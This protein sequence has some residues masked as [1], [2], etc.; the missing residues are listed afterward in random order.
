M[1]TE[2]LFQFGVGGL[3]AGDTLEHSTKIL[4]GRL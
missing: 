4:P 2:R 3:L 1:I